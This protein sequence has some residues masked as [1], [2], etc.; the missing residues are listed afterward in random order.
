[1]P[2]HAEQLAQELNLNVKNVQGAIELIDPVSYTHLFVGRQQNRRCI[3]HKLQA[4]AVTGS[5]QRRAARGLARCG[6][7][8]ENIVGLPARLA[9]LHKAK[10][11][12]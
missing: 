11:C 7:R 9:D 5:Q 3:V 6:Q 1:M 4:V 8:A 2:N 10:R 12:V